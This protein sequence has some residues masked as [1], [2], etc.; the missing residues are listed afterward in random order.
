MMPKA[1]KYNAK[2]KFS[3][4]ELGLSITQAIDGEEGE[5]YIISII[6]I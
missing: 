5:G 3:I 6:L 2:L 4:V 1:V